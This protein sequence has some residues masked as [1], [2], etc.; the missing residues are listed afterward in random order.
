M[1]YEDAS[2]REIGA[3]EELSKAVA[4]RGRL[5]ATAAVYTDHKEPY[6]AAVERLL[7]AVQAYDAA[8][9]DLMEAR[10]PR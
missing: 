2:R 6:E 5:D 4:A 7:A 10:S 3:F 8:S 9:T 1:S